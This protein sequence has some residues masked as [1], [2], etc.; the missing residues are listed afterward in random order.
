MIS[1]A[2][3][4]DSTGWSV[5]RIDVTTAG[6]R[7]NELEINSQPMTCEDSASSTSQ[8]VAESEGVR[9]RSPMTSPIAAQPIADE[10]VAVNRVRP[11]GAGLCSPVAG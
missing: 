10:S 4:T 5:S 8:P 11:G 3:I 6:N 9:S 7:G 1:A 2:K